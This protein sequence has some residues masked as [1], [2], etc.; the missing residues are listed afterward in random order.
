MT[1]SGND[2]PFTRKTKRLER[3]RLMHAIALT[4]V[5]GVIVSSLSL[6]H[7]YGASKTSFC[8]FG[9]SFNCDIVNRSVYSTALGALTLEV[10][11]RYQRIQEGRR[12]GTK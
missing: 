6:Y 4:A 7:H 2:R 9:E 11:Y 5:A 3:P 10:Y 8:N 12:P 1:F